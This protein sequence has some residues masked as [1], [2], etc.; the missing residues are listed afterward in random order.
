MHCTELYLGNKGIEKIRGFDDFVNLESL[1]LNGNKLKKINNLD[2]NFRIKV[3]NAQDNQIC[4][5]KGSLS[6]FSNLEQ[7]DLSGNQLRDLAKLL[8]VLQRFQFLTHL[9]LKDNPCCEEPDYRMLVV[10]GMPGLRVL[11]QHVITPAERMKSEVAIG[12]SVS[13]LTIAFGKRAPVRDGTWDAK[14]PERSLLEQEL[15]K[16]AATC[17]QTRVLREQNR[18]LEQFSHNPHPDIPKGKTLPP[19]AGTMRNTAREAADGNAAMGRT[20][21]GPTAT[22]RERPGDLS[23]SSYGYMHR[24]D[25]FVLSST[26]VRPTELLSSGCSLTKPIPGSIHLEQRK[27]EAFVQRKAQG[28]LGQWNVGQTTLRL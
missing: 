22:L 20:D 4:T 23:S 5:L 14:V 15:V 17:R 10:H 26:S 27:Y 3:L 13:A 18:E 2:Q 12:G 1:C 8:P 7:L 28:G 21:A 6:C 11:D 25:M 19:N 24:G 16:E 9:N